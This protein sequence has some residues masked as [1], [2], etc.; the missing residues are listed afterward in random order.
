MPYKPYTDPRQAREAFGTLQTNY[1][2][3][4][5]DIFIRAVCVE[6]RRATF[7]SHQTS[8]A[9]GE[10]CALTLSA[11]IFTLINH[12]KFLFRRSR[13][14]QWIWIEYTLICKQ[15][16]N[17]HE[18]FANDLTIEPYN[19]QRIDN[20]NEIIFNHSFRLPTSGKHIQPI[21]H[22]PTIKLN[23]NMS[24][25]TEKWI[26]MQR[27]SCWK[28]HVTISTTVNSNCSVVRAE[29]KHLNEQHHP[30]HPVDKVKDVYNP[31]FVRTIDVNLTNRQT[32]AREPM[33]FGKE[34][35]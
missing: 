16:H 9:I 17:S 25:R 28:L 26:S 21:Q 1:N 8:I 2:Q 30:L 29:R 34:P 10:S 4:D 12:R 3:I 35:A 27:S 20:F 32:N 24:I 13:T 14:A 22:H 6:W 23:R 18:I 31:G 15:I 5:W 33:K 7:Q 11:R 19:D